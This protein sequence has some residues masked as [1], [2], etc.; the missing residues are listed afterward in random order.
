MFS[1]AALCYEYDLWKSLSLQKR[2]ASWFY[3]EINIIYPGRLFYKDKIRS[4]IYCAIKCDVLSRTFL[5][6]DY[7]LNIILWHGNRN[8]L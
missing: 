2:H 6:I 5:C 1:I 3:I 4:F 7:E 8:S